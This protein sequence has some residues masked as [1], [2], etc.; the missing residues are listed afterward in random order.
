MAEANTNVE[1]QKEEKVAVAG[2]MDLEE[3]GEFLDASEVVLKN[4]FPECELA[5]SDSFSLIGC[6]HVTHTS[7]AALMMYN[8][9][10]PY[11]SI[12]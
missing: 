3:D 6:D 8:N 1:A 9:F 10:M 7:T 12:K 11:C 4:C 2:S 5:D